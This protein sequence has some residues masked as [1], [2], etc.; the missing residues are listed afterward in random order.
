MDINNIPQDKIQAE[1][2]L[3]ARKELLL[4]LI[5]ESTCKYNTVDNTLELLHNKLSEVELKLKQ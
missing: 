1:I 4:E 2:Y 3:L 5:L